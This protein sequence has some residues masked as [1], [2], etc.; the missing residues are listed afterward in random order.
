[1]AARKRPAAGEQSAITLVRLK[2]AR[3]QIEIEGLSPLIPHRW[4]EKAKRMMPG[5]VDPETGQAPDKMAK[6]EA[7]RRASTG[8]RMGGPACQRRRSRRRWSR[9]AGSSRSQ[10]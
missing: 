8:W 3:V 6:K 9:R 7:R 2:D 10:A 1:M 4:S 5:Y